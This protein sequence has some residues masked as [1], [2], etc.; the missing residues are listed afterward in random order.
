MGSS[1]TRK[2]RAIVAADRQMEIDVRVENGAGDGVVDAVDEVFVFG[3]MLDPDGVQMNRGVEGAEEGKDVDDLEGVGGHLGLID[4]WGEFGGRRKEERE[5]DVLGE[6]QAAVV[7]GVVADVDAES[8]AAV[9]SLGGGGEL[10]VDLVAD[11][12]ADGAGGGEI[13][14]VTAD[15]E[16]DREI[17]ER[18]RWF[19]G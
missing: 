3:A 9:A 4:G 11:L 14:I 13:G 12:L 16:G 15:V 1:R 18:P 10:G 19:R 5:R 6:V 2:R 17:E 7:E 8:V